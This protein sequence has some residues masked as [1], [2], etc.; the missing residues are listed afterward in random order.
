MINLNRN[1]ANQAMTLK[2]KKINK[3]AKKA[4]EKLNDE[5]LRSIKLMFD[6]QENGKPT[7]NG[8]N[9]QDLTATELDKRNNVLMKELTMLTLENPYAVQQDLLKL[10]PYYVQDPGNFMEKAFNG[11]IETLNELNF[12]SENTMGARF[13]NDLFTNPK[14]KQ[15]LKGILNATD[16][17]I[18][19]I[20]GV[21]DSVLNPIRKQMDTRSHKRTVIALG[22]TTL[23]LIYLTQFSAINQS[24]VNLKDKALESLPVGTEL[25]NNVSSDKILEL[26]N[27]FVSS[28]NSSKSDVVNIANELLYGNSNTEN[29]RIIRR[30]KDLITNDDGSKSLKVKIDTTGDAEAEFL[31]N[32]VLFRNEETTE[33]MVLFVPIENNEQKVSSS[34]EIILIS[35]SGDFY[36]SSKAIPELDKYLTP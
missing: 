35:N 5:S 26:S 30:D 11:K 33:T 31:A 27:G 19:N 32:L 6:Y 2:T 16:V 21:E 12:S 14:K 7:F 36:K 8:T 17:M 23:S 3:A 15:E 25:V 1:I 18:N 22:T 9:V 24:L 34:Q 10:L 13:W 29:Y 28:D 4:A 20:S